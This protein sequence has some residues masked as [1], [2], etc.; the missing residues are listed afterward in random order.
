MLRAFRDGAAGVLIHG[1]ASLGKSSLAARIVSRMGT[2]KPVVVFK[3]Y[4]AL[5]VFDRLVEALPTPERA[6]VRATWRDAVLA[7]PAT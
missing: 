3:Q 5:T 2:R 1:M 4:D 6:A 7:E